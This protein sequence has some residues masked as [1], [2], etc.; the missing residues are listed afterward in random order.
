MARPAR[1]AP[2]Q[3]ARSAALDARLKDLFQAI[4][5]EPAPP[6]LLRHVEALE[7]RGGVNGKGPRKR[8]P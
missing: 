2:S 1:P 5:A 4:A 7:Q 8:R 3:A 6:G